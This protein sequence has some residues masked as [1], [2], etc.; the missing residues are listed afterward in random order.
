MSQDCVICNHHLRSDTQ[1][2]ALL[3][4]R[5]TCGTAS[6]NSGALYSGVPWKPTDL[7]MPTPLLAKLLSD[8][9]AN[10]KSTRYTQPVL[11]HWRAQVGRTIHGEIERHT[12][13]ATRHAS[14][15][16]HVGRLEIAVDDASAVDVSEQAALLLHYYIQKTGVVGANAAYSR[17]SAKQSAMRSTSARGSGVELAGAELSGVG[18]I[19]L[20]SGFPGISVITMESSGTEGRK[21]RT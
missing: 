16:K 17:T 15:L 19:T 5:H 20:C 12:S 4:S 10:P 11:S 2:I 21:P 1:I 7:D 14:H 18:C 3:T 8:A 13:R 6:N 9:T